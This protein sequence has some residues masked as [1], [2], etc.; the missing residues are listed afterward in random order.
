MGHTH[1]SDSQL[2]G[3]REHLLRVRVRIP[4]KQAEV[5]DTWLVSLPPCLSSLQPPEGAREYLSQATSCQCS[6]PSMAPTSEQKPK[7]SPWSTRPCRLYPVP[8]PPSLPP[9]LPS[10]SLLQPYGPSPTCWMKSC[11][12][13]FALA[14]PPSPGLCVAPFLTSSGLFPTL[15]VSGGPSLATLF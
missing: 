12:R 15:T 8:S 11:L 14:G 9:T 13:T 6:E 3:C 10:L 5:A 7:P 4:R 2:G 1:S